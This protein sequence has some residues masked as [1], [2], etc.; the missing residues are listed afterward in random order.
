[1]MSTDNLN[2]NLI[3]NRSWKTIDTKRGWGTI[4]FYIKLGNRL[5]GR[6]NKKSTVWEMSVGDVMEGHAPGKNTDTGGVY[7]QRLG[8]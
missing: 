2:E 3:T 1:M 6:I 8:F 5:L 7:M 4:M